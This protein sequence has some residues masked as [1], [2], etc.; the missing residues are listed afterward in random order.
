[1]VKVKS[2][3]INGGLAFENFGVSK[4]STFYPDV[5]HIKK[6]LI[7]IPLVYLWMCNFGFG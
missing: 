6:S 5:K 7:L 4:S 3:K 1:M 2:A